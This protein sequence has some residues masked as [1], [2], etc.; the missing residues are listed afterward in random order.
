M[1]TLLILM[2]SVLALVN[3]SCTDKD[4]LLMVEENGKVLSNGGQAPALLS[5]NFPNPFSGATTITYGVSTRMKITL[6]VMTE[7]WVNVKTLVDT[8]KP[9]GLYRVVWK[10]GNFPS[11]EY[12]AVLKG[13]GV[14]EAI[15]MRL[16]K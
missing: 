8:V 4:R 13:G 6:E 9:A 14:T 10:A 3:N 5:Q 11:G 7:D 16:L 2:F 12:L 15:R 1:K